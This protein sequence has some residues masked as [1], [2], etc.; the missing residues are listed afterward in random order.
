MRLANLSRSTN[1]NGSITQRTN[2]NG[3]SDSALASSQ[4]APSRPV[5]QSNVNVP[6]ASTPVATVNQ[7]MAVNVFPLPAAIT[8]TVA[9]AAG[10]GAAATLVTVFN[11]DLFALIDD[12]G[13]GAG[14]ITYTF[15]DGTA[16]GVVNSASMAFARAGVGA[17]IYGYTLRMIVTA[18]RAGDPVGLAAA[19][20]QFRTFNGFGNNIPLNT[21]TTEDQT[22]GDFDTSI[23]VTP[24]LINFTRMTQFG[25]IIPVAD[26]ATAT[27]YTTNNFK[28]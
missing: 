2:G 7:Y 18:T 27:L 28:R 17:I 10:A 13:S 1:V 19:N 14:S 15:M 26:T 21:N 24:V 8:V 5:T 22:R 25:F 6:G 23:D 11:N 3:A 20:A 12:N 16:T 9:S 4:V